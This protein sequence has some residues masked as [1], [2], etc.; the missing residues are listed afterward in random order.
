M[1]MQTSNI[2]K[3][4]Q[5][6]QIKISYSYFELYELVVYQFIENYTYEKYCFHR[7]E[8]FNIPERN[9]AVLGVYFL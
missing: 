5:F 1:I 7:C 8:P 9:E 3:S 4:K 6:C 2:T